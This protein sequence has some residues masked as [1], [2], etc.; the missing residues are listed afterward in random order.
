MIRARIGDFI[1][2]PVVGGLPCCRRQEKTVS[3]NNAA[4]FRR[5]RCGV[6][7]RVGTGSEV[8]RVRDRIAA[9]GP[10][11]RGIQG[12]AGRTVRGRRVARQPDGDEFVQH[13]GRQGT[14]RQRLRIGECAE[15][16]P[17]VGADGLI[18][19]GMAGHEG[20]AVQRGG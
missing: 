11:Q 7:H 13:N 15:R 8:N 2:A 9:R 5:G 19:A 4:K 3:G 10:T 18:D 20:A 17:G 6:C 16:L 14:R 1:H 12:N